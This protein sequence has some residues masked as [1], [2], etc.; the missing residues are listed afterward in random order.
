MNIAI[1]TYGMNLKP[2]SQS[3]QSPWFVYREQL[4]KEDIHII[5]ITE[6][7]DAWKEALRKPYDAMMLFVWQD[8]NNK[9]HYRHARTMEILSLYSI[10][11]S[12]F[13]TVQ[14]VCNHTDWCRDP[15]YSTHLWR[16]DDPILYRTPAYNRDELKPYS[17]T[18][19]WPY[20][21]CWGGDNFKGDRITNMAGFIGYP[22][23]P[24]GYRE[25]VAK[26]VSEVGIGMC[27]QNKID[28]KLH[29]QIMGSC[30]IIV[31]P[32][33]WGETTSRHWDAWLSKKV[34][35]TDYDCDA[36]E[37]IPGQRPKHGEQYLLYDK[38]EDIPDIV[39]DWCRPGKSDDLERIALEGYKMA[40]LY[41]AKERLKEF[42]RR[43]V[44][45]LPISP[46]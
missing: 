35:L 13:D 7:F 2:W 31:C 8:W 25:K 30:R 46:S 29:N 26:A 41:D 22:S 43:A 1:L 42:F 28:N 9:Q 36:V 37:I 14:I 4:A 33:G 32:R 18:D 10:Y 21:I 6:S 45:R 34:V 27:I 17:S 23:G 38:P 16:R 3:G 12:N 39:A 19:I 40:R 24:Q 15:F 5:L 44:N 20:E 11:R